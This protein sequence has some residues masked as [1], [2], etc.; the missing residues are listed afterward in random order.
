M[1]H[2]RIALLPLLSVLL[3]LASCRSEYE[4]LLAGNDGDLKYSTAF[5]Y[6]NQGKYAKAAQLFESL[7]AMTD[8][9]ARDDTVR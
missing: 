5:D 1:K 6:F 3:A 2:L 8:G 9:T 7:A 4:M